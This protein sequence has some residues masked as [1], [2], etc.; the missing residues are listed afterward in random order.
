M[1]AKCAQ[2]NTTSSL[3]T[4]R[5]TLR[6]VK[7]SETH[8]DAVHWAHGASASSVEEFRFKKKRRSSENKRVRQEQRIIF[9]APVNYD[10]CSTKSKAKWLIAH[11]DDHVEEF[12]QPGDEVED[13]RFRSAGRRGTQS[14]HPATF[15]TKSPSSCSQSMR[16]R[17]NSSTQ[18]RDLIGRNDLRVVHPRPENPR[19]LSDATG[20]CVER[21][22]QK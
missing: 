21:I 5:L 15:F 16:L 8:S 6:E 11:N 3:R 22:G 17:G 9:T 19:V 18:R 13:Q 12:V 14:I 4:G 20:G 1:P 2:V 10:V 7:T